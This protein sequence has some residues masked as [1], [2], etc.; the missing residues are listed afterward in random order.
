MSVEVDRRWRLVLGA[1]PENTAGGG[2][3]SDDAAMDKALAALYDNDGPGG[4]RR[5]GLG[6][7]APKVARWLGDIRTYFPSRV[8]QVMQGD[9]IDRL[10]LKRLLLEP[11]MMA[12]VQPDVHLVA[13]LASLGRVMPAKAKETAR[14]RWAVSLRSMNRR[15]RC[16]QSGPRRCPG[17]SQLQVP[18]PQ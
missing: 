9:A 3:S 1:D 12:S 5:A 16:R 17:R 7:S 13:T 4:T 6:G 8:V 11:E 18:R 2:L 15:W 14:D 10:G